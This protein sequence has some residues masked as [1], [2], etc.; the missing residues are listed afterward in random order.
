LRDWRRGEPVFGG[1]WQLCYCV[2]NL[3]PAAQLVAVEQQAPDGSWIIRQSCHTIE[4]RTEAARRRGTIVREHAAPVEWD[5][6]PARPPRLRFTLRGLGKVRIEAAVLGSAK[7]AYRIGLPRPLLGHP[8]PTA[9]WPK[10]DWT[11]IADA[12]E[13]GVRPHRD[14]S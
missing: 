3:A 5:G 2:R 1:E 9:G 12:V 7:R 4:F 8:A 13:L 6:D 10:L 14:Q 11:V